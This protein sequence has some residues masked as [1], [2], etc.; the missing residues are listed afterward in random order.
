MARDRCTF[1][2]PSTPIPPDSPAAFAES[3]RAHVEHHIGP[4]HGSTR[5]Y[6]GRLVAS[7]VAQL[8]DQWAG[9]DKVSRPEGADS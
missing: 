7:I 4:G 2:R 8:A 6:Y 3:V 9:W 5:A 1:Y